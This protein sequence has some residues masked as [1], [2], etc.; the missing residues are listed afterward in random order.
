MVVLKLLLRFSV[1]NSTGGSSC[2]GTLLPMEL[3]MITVSDTIA[4]PTTSR[5]AIRI[6][7]H[8]VWESGERSDGSLLHFMGRRASRLDDGLAAGEAG[9]KSRPT[10]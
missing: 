2:V 9:G 3:T 7:A 10:H 4:P 5:D 1:L 8:R 6:N